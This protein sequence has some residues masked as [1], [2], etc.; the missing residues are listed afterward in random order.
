[1]FKN[2]HQ[3]LYSNQAIVQ[4]R[5]QPWWVIVVLY[6][7]S[8]MLISTPFIAEGYR[9][10]SSTLASTFEPVASLFDQA[11]QEDCVIEENVLS[12]SFEEVK[13]FTEG[14]YTLYLNESD[15]ASLND[16]DNYLLLSKNY[17]FG[18]VDGQSVVGMYNLANV[19]PLSNLKTSGMSSA[20]ILGDFL[21]NAHKGALP[22]RV[23]M[24]YA[25]NVFQYLVYIL[26]VAL[27]LRFVNGRQFTLN[28]S[29]KEALAIAVM[30]MFAPALI[31][32][33]IGLFNP[34]IATLFYPVAYMARIVLVYWQIM[35]LQRSTN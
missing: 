24:I 14:D 19:G 6:L 26:V 34:S 30:T 17:V 29:F 35:K 3:I 12:C 16:L 33:I 32:A 4:Q 21:E 1:M 10:G 8:A 7:L 31:S 15:D 25:L 22:V 23:P 27:V 5:N 2:F 9:L 13:T 28:L 11:L 18:L 20:M